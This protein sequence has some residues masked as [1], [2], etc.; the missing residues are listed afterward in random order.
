VLFVADYEQIRRRHGGDD[1]PPRFLI[2][3]GHVPLALCLFA[4]EHP[5]I[6]ASPAELW[7]EA[8]KPMAEW[9]RRLAWDA[10]ALMVYVCPER[11]RRFVEMGIYHICG[12]T[13]DKV[14]LA[15]RTAYPGIDKLSHVIFLSGPHSDT[16]WRE[17]CNRGE[18]SQ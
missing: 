12:A 9:G 13:A 7:V 16:V 18:C 5:R 2:H 10:G 8:S 6:Y 11:G 3:R 1:E 17:R 14:E 4:P 15:R